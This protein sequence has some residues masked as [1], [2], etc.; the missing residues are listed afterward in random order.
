[1]C[2][3][4]L[5]GGRRC[6][7]SYAPRRSASDRAYYAAKKAAKATLARLPDSAPVSVTVPLVATP[8]TIRE[9]AEVAALS[10]NKS[11]L[12]AAKAEELGVDELNSAAREATI[13]WRKDPTDD[14]AASKAAAVAAATAA[15]NE[16]TAFE[17][18][19]PTTAEAELAVVQVGQMIAERAEM[20]AGITGEQA[21]QEYEKRLKE[22]LDAE[23]AYDAAHKEAKKRLIEGP[24]EDRE[25]AYE[26]VNKLRAEGAPAKDIEAARLDAVAK[27]AVFSEAN[28]ALSA[29]R[30]ENHADEI[31]QRAH[32]VS[33]A[34]DDD[35]KEALT[36]LASGYTKALAEV[37]ETGGDLNWDAK[38][39]KKVAALFSEA[40][41]VFPSEW[42]EAS[43]DR[44]APLAKLSKSRAHYAD[45]KYT[46]TK[47][48]E[49]V[50][51]QVVMT[52]EEMARRVDGSVYGLSGDYVLA[53]DQSRGSSR[54]GKVYR[55]SEYEVF[56][57]WRHNSRNGK[58]VG[59][60]WREVS[61]VGDDGT[62]EKTWRRPKT[63]LVT[64]QAEFAPEITTN[65]DAAR[66]RSAGYATAVHEMT[67]RMEA[68]V[69]AIGRMEQAFIL[70]RTTDET[71]EREK[72]VN[73]YGSSRE[74]A[75]PDN[76]INPYM[77]KEYK[78]QTTYYEVMSCGTQGLFGGDFGGF[79]GA[80]KGAKA[81]PDYRSFV[82][83][84]M[85]TARREPKPV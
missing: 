23:A 38:T 84:V 19:L 22:A 12:I 72:L 66:V 82:L 70:R 55:Y 7:C 67:H 25:V 59:T 77:G 68:S 54:E 56:N 73:L 69:P 76:F 3:E 48:R 16:V 11:A 44:K 64:V 8:E 10:F 17:R 14:N 18:S 47:K 35:T 37:R 45:S 20:H 36:R 52:D 61:Y 51:Y 63:K 83:G 30:V 27:T 13:R 4:I 33:V 31:R 6:P 53:E 81:D 85:A 15:M 49:Q 50:S 58:P 1:M 5:A 9:R 32:L 29:W 21:G 43:N 80:M 40:G 41:Q 65:L 79:V 62:T 75:R 78:G 28:Q 71:G 2:R 60:G 26:K 74:R 57:D 34:L 39:Q 24:H 42:V 46:K